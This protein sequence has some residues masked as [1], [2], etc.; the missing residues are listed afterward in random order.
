MPALGFLWP[1]ATATG[2]TDRAGCDAVLFLTT[3]GFAAFTIV[4]IAA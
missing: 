1:V 4:F 2:G 3:A